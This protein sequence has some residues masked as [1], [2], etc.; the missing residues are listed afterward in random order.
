M[1]LTGAAA[2]TVH[3][4]AI[5]VSGVATAPANV[6]SSWPAARSRHATAGERRSSWSLR[7]SWPSVIPKTHWRTRVRRVNEVS[8]HID[9]RATASEIPIVNCKQPTNNVSLRAGQSIRASDD[10]NIYM[11]EMGGTDGAHRTQPCFYRLHRWRSA[12]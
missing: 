6:G 2:G 1:P 4:M 10:A 8:P 5:V 3:G 7:S 11:R 9:E 12:A